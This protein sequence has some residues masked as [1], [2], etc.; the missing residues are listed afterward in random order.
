MRGLKDKVALV[1]GGAGGNGS[2]A[3]YRMGEEGCKVVVADFAADKAEAV[4]EK[5]RAAGGQAVSCF[6]DLGDETTVE[7]MA[8]FAAETYGTIDILLNIAYAPPYMGEDSTVPFTKVDPELFLNV[9]KINCVGYVLTIKHVLPYFLKQQRGVIVNTSST[10]GTYGNPCRVAYSASKAAIISLASNIAVAYGKMGVRCN[11]L[12]LGHIIH[13][14][15]LDMEYPGVLGESI[16]HNILTP[17][18]AGEKDVAAAFAFLASDDSAHITA[19]VVKLDDGLKEHT[20][21]LPAIN[22][23]PD[24]N[25]AYPKCFLP[26]N[27]P[28]GWSEA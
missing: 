5:I 1:V 23:N 10:D 2:A 12:V 15:S 4:A 24:E 9:Y 19:D 3:C 28:N 14:S 8:R 21:L 26:E 11:T 20:P 25:W 17:A 27:Y 16:K 6:V 13:S 7:A 18:P 22:T